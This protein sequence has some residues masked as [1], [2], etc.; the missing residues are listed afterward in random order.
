MTLNQ[1]IMDV[2][3]GQGYLP[4]SDLR[5]YH[6]AQAIK[7]A[8]RRHDPLEKLS[9]VREALAQ[10]RVSAWLEPDGKIRLVIQGETVATL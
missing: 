10:Y 3:K 4:D 7:A 9:G 6:K 5:D 8:L 2:I 1:R